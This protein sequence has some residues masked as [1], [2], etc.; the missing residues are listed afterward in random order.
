MMID[1]HTHVLFGVDDGADSPEMSMEL[2]NQ[3]VSLGVTKILATPHVDAHTSAE[4]EDL[5]FRTYGSL[6]EMIIK[7][8]LSVELKLAAEVNLIGSGIDWLEHSW[9]LIGSGQRYILV[10]TPFHQLPSDFADILFRIRLNKIVPILAHPER[11]FGFQENASELIEWINQGALVQTDAGSL[12]GQ[13]G[14]E[15]QRFSERLLR[16]GAIHLVASDAHHP[17]GRNYNVLKYACARI[18][19]VAGSLR[20]AELS[21]DNPL[22]IWNGEPLAVNQPDAAL[23]APGFMDKIRRLL[24]SP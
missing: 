1:L 13:F 7:E 9:L 15:C 6:S 21:H 14:R 19:E 20:A 2:I 4:A 11:N 22:K 16:A 24:T 5:I 17:Q 23:I 10:E 8:N 3:A 12:T 18:E